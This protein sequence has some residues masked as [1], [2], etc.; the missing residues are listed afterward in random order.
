MARRPLGR[1]TKLRDSSSRRRRSPYLLQQSDTPRQTLGDQNVPARIGTCNMEGRAGASRQALLSSQECGV[2]VDV[3][4]LLAD[5]DCRPSEN[6]AQAIRGRVVGCH[7]TQNLP[8]PELISR[9]W[10]PRRGVEPAVE[11]REQLGTF[12]GADRGSRRV[13]LI[14][15]PLAGCK[16]VDERRAV[17]A[18]RQGRQ[19]LPLPASGRQGVLQGRDIDQWVPPAT[20]RDSAGAE[21][22]W[23]RGGCR[24]WLR[25]GESS[26]VTVHGFS[27]SLPTKRLVP[28]SAL[29]G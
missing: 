11:K 27:V 3:E 24:T 29:S 19:C 7:G 25:R 26:T 10:E 22:R 16:G 28:H 1:P 6:Q 14:C 18:S 20:V 8:A 13:T 2:A 4:V 12:A 15:S 5:F 17:Q 21:R 23:G 9:R